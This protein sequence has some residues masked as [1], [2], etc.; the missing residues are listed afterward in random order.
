MNSKKVFLIFYF[1]ISIVSVF[2]NT[3]AE[4]EQEK[5]ERFQGYNDTTYNIFLILLG[6]FLLL[7][8]ISMMLIINYF[9]FKHLLNY[10]LIVLV[11]GGAIILAIIFNIP[12]K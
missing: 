7:C 3:Y 1:L 6:L 9:G 8:V 5:I 11:F 10:I 12:L 2:S 4:T